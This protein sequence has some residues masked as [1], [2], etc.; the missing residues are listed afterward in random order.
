[1]RNW[2]SAETDD[3]PAGGAEPAR[4]GEGSQ[5]ARIAIS[6]P[7]RLLGQL[8][9]M[10][11]RRGSPSR[12]QMIA[13][14][15][16]HE[17]AQGE[18]GEADDL[19]AGAITLIYRKESDRVSHGLMRVQA[20]FLPEVI[21]SQRVF[22]EEDQSLE[23][24]LVQGTSRRLEQLCDSLRAVRAV[25]QLTLVATRSLLPPLHAPGAKTAGAL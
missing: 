4:T 13:E 20:A 12:S 24:L 19:L 23:V 14:L 2:A 5:T 1:M 22:L 6:L 18:G 17:L 10:V 25:R 9:D 3:R 7:W 15:A 16:R 8:D 11:A 21:S